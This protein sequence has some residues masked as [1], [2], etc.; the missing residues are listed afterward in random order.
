[1]KQMIKVGLLLLAACVMTGQLLSQ[2]IY[3]VKRGERPPINVSKLSPDAWE[4]G[5]I[6]IKIKP[7]LYESFSE[8][9]L[10][11][12][13]ADFVTTGHEEMD[14]LNKV[15]GIREY[16]P[17]FAALNEANTLSSQLQ[18]RHKAWG[19]NLWYELTMDSRADVA[20]AVRQFSALAD[21]EFAEPEY[22]KQLVIDDPAFGK[23][24]SANPAGDSLIILWS[25]N[26]PQYS[27]QWHYN[28]TGQQAGTPGADI[29]LQQ[30]WDVEK[31]NSNI[32]VAIVDGGIQINHS[33]IAAN[34]WSGIGYNFVNN[35]PTLIAH[36]HGTHV[37]GTVAAVNSNGVG[38]SGVAGG[39][40]SGD[41]VRL[42]S[43]QVFTAS[44][45]GGFH[46]APVYA[47]DN[48]ACISQNSWG[49]TYVGVYDAA[50]LDAIDYFNLHGGG[51]VMAGG[52]TI[53]AAG[54]SNASG[55][56][57][58]GCYSGAFSVAA[59]S[60]QD[61]KAWY[62]NYDTWIDVSAPGG[63]TNSL[64]ARG[65]LSTLTGNT[66]GYYQGT[67]MACPHVSGVAALMASYANRNGLMLTNDD[68]KYILKNATDDHY[69][70]NP[71]YIGKLGTGRVN[72]LK[73]LNE[74]ADM[75]A[76]VMNP[77]F[78]NADASGSNQI[79]LT[80]QK[81]QQVDDV[82]VAWSYTDNIGDPTEGETYL[83]GQVIP[84]G[85]VV[86]YRGGNTTFQHTDLTDATYYYYKIWSVN[87]LN[88]Y[89]AGRSTMESTDCMVVTELPFLEDF[90][91]GT[92]LPPCWAIIDNKSLG[93]VWE[94]GIFTFR[95]IGTTGNV[96]FLNSDGY[97]QGN[98]QNS[99]IISPTFDFSGYTDVTL[100]FK[101]Y[102]RQY[103]SASTAKL[104]Y[105]IDNGSTW[106]TI[107]TW[108]ST[109]PNPST[110]NEQ[111]AA[112]DGQQ[113]VKFKWNFTGTWAYYWSI[114]DI[115][116]TGISEEVA[117]FIADPLICEPGDAV[118]FTD[119]TTA[120]PYSTWQWNFGNGAVPAS[121]TGQGPHQVVYNTSG[122]KTITVLVDGIHFREKSDYV[123]VKQLY[124]LSLNFSG[125]GSVEVDGI[126]YTEP[127]S[128][129]EGSI[130]SLQANADV[131]SSFFSWDG[132]LTGNTNPVNL[133]MN[134]AKTV[135][136]NFLQTATATYTLG[137]L[138][139]DDAFI[140]TNGASACPGMLAITIPANAV[141]LGVDVSY[142]MTALNSSWMS[143]QRSQLRCVS[144][145]GNQET[146]LH[147]GS[148]NSIG[149]FSYNRQGLDIANEVSGGGN[150][151]FELHAGRT[152]SSSGYAGCQTYNNK[153]NNN[154][155]TVT[156]HYQPNP[157]LPIVETLPLS[158]ILG[159]S[160]VGA[161]NVIS[162]G[163]F[164]V[165][166]RGFYWGTQSKP[167][168]TG[169]KLQA[170]SGFGSYTHTIDNLLAKT[171]YY[172]KA[173]ATNNAGTSYGSE[174]AFYTTPPADVILGN[175]VISSA[176]DTCMDAT[177]TITVAGGGTVFTVNSGG[178]V[179]LVA[180]QNII[181]FDGTQISSGGYLRAYIDTTG[182]YCNNPQTMLAADDET[183]FISQ[184][185]K[186]DPA[187]KEGL[188]SSDIQTPFY[189]VYPNPTSGI[190]KIDLSEVSESENIFI[191]VFGMMGE[192]ISSEIISGSQNYELNLTP[193][194]AGVYIVRILQGQRM[195]VERIIKR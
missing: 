194:P 131:G 19:L 5:R 39:S 101:H 85:G 20:E 154:T 92:E 21:I 140:T 45:S 91:A 49:Y 110:F 113:A 166:E 70:V 172:V 128:F 59:T 35:T 57:Y 48:G 159:T 171:L 26:D 65:V 114:D 122:H 170:G 66:Y 86:L 88:Q 50:I 105:S 193:H 138:P 182:E 106:Q 150:I 120:G 174:I 71:N 62:S 52:I 83:P 184:S 61:K 187:L 4:A 3:E 181:F 14:E 51:N 143:Q 79:N 135:A 93:Q 28:N 192:R 177:H 183:E 7:A 27:A 73:A 160:A 130:V 67:S 116:V 190:L 195:G 132:D 87:D 41:G 95:V 32:I 158:D 46:L 10:N 155:W 115:S 54:N 34:M 112:V 58:P 124:P 18:E 11:S 42:M 1:M 69:D 68:M 173:Y 102:F 36:N 165:T 149:T 30:A 121:A 90:N 33:D 17:L 162:E 29:S 152:Q 118:L 9:T 157:S 6:K 8:R 189:S 117:N 100:S 148:G 98:T 145:G 180:G 136:A 176:L 94:I 107:Q 137:D 144:P 125:N 13:E 74:V 81:N 164:T 38:V 60:N 119:A 103:S 77:V 37:A 179:N 168:V 151:L 108:T 134:S 80:W 2:E 129:P 178:S 53:F 55:Q 163:G 133:L 40:G 142:Q 99:D 31:G 43:C 84:G 23:K 161:G 126:A 89:S 64:S 141:I 167:E 186:S 75:M 15:Y 82:V 22:K 78:F 47:A 25:P 147:A 153:V 127:V 139:T 96:A 63:E 175:L 185:E 16:K 123:Y 191:E 111:I 156:V 109:I 44:S 56:W 24:E 97:G 146:M 104:S 76:T 12:G 72:A 169:F 188:N